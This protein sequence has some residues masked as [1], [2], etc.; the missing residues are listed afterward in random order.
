[1]FLNYI[2]NYLS[3]YFIY[4][5]DINLERARAL[6]TSVLEVI[7]LENARI[8]AEVVEKDE[9]DS[10]LRGI[11]NYGHTIG[12]AIE[13]VSNFQLKHGQA[14]A[15]GMTAAARIANKMGTLDKSDVIRLTNV[16]QK[17]GLP[18]EMTNLNIKD[19]IQAMKH[20][21][22]VLQDKIRFVL[23]KSIGDAFITDKVSPSLVEEVLVGQE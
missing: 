15:I 11:L 23:L 21:K 8:K 2:I 7:I 19:I 9:K 4:F 5:L 3:E 10:G 18:I 16:I 14:V 22:K 6:N 13:A 20:D 1:M 12:H 17:A